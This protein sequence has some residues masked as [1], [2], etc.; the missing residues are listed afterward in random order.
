MFWQRPAS[1][2]GQILIGNWELWDF[3]PC[4]Q[5]SISQ[6]VCL[7]PPAWPDIVIARLGCQLFIN[8]DPG[9]EEEE[10]AP[11]PGYIGPGPRQIGLGNNNTHY[12]HGA[13]TVFPTSRE[14]ALRSATVLQ[15]SEYYITGVSSKL[16]KHCATLHFWGAGII[17]YVAAVGGP[18]PLILTDTDSGL[19]SLSGITRSMG[20]C[21]QLASC[22]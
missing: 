6:S 5:F 12:N 10:G 3:W 20:R 9:A 8:L 4:S 14:S 1:L 16:W 21:W 15:V 19:L 2:S 18:A 17:V 13:P 22:L 11:T 7:L